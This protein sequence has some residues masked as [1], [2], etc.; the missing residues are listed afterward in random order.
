M[1]DF[2]NLFILYGPGTNLAHSASLLLHAEFQVHYAMEAIRQ[3]L[4]ADARTIEVKP[5]AH[6]DHVARYRDEIDQLIW[7]RPGRSTSTGS[8]PAPSTPT[9]TSSPD[10]EG[11]RR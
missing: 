4:T 7:S 9:T 1:P 2:P 6:A 10:P 5:G 3:V 11:D 8:G